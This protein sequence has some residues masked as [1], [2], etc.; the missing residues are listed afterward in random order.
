MSMRAS[1]AHATCAP[2]LFVSVCKDGP[3]LLLNDKASTNS[4]RGDRGHLPCDRLDQLGW[5]G[6]AI[7]LG[8]TQRSHLRRILRPGQAARSDAGNDLPEL[9]DG[10]HCGKWTRP[11]LQSFSIK[12]DR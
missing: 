9:C 3:E 2:L 10:E 5:V 1:L 11:G 6:F 8:T 4:L 7:W 12:P